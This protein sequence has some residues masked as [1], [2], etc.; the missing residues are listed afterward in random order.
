MAHNSVIPASVYEA[1]ASI[2][3]KLPWKWYGLSA[4]DGT[5]GDWANAQV[6]SEYTY[7]NSGVITKYIKTA[8]AQATADWRVMVSTA[9]R[10]GHVGIPLTTL[11]KM[12]SADLGDFVYRNRK[13]VRDIPLMAFRETVSND[14]GVNATTPAGGILTK[15]TTPNLEFA[16]GDTD[17]QLRLEWAAA[18]VDAIYTQVSLPSDLDL[19]ENITLYVRGE[20]AG[21]TDVTTVFTVESFFNEGDTK[22]TDTTAA[23]AAA[24]GN[25]AATIAAAD[26]GLTAGAGGTMSIELTLGAHGTDAI[27]AYAVWLEYYVSSVDPLLSTT[28]GDTDGAPIMTWAAAEVT[29]VWFSVPLAPDLDDASV[30]EVHVRAKMG[31]STDTMTLDLDSYFNEGDTKVEDTVSVS[32]TTITEYTITIAAADVPSG[33]QTFTGELTPG[34]HGT[35]AFSLYGLWVEYTRT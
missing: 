33:A 22:V 5:T 10:T 1:H 32:G 16:N 12:H 3:G 26:I 11:R 34:T 18:N 15:D 35:D 30:V 4:V 23:M 31:G 20:S 17:S 8:N 21:T 7:N 6:G 27:Y 14:V 24:V 29:P 28:N 13:V 2:D 25:R 9:S 19:S